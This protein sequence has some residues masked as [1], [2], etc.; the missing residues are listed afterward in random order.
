M[1]H[2]IAKDYNK[3][4]AYVY[5]IFLYAK[6]QNTLS[7]VALFNSSLFALCL[8]IILLASESPTESNN[9]GDISAFLLFAILSYCAFSNKPTEKEIKKIKQTTLYKGIVKALVALL[10][11]VW[12][13]IFIYIF[14]I[15]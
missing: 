10:V 3:L 2:K 15:F 1:F 4:T 12:S 9:A 14:S 13:A 11:F 8:L 5:S 6:K 7:F